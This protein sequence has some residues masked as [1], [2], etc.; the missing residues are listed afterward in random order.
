MNKEEKE[1]LYQN[2]LKSGLTPKDFAIANN[3]NPAIIRGLV[4][5]HKRIEN[6]EQ[7]SFITISTKDSNQYESKIIAFK[8]DKH[9]IEIDQSLLKIFLGAI[10]D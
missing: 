6:N 10:Y 8:F 5:F 4:S 2:Y 7:S 1:I 9:L 3:I